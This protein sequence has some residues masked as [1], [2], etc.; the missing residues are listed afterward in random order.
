LQR[1]WHF[2]LRIYLGPQPAIDVEVLCHT[3]GLPSPEQDHGEALLMAV[4]EWLDPSKTVDWA[5][6]W[7]DV[8]EQLLS[9]LR[10]MDQ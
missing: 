6:S 5:S 9:D 8:A 10:F 1:I 2:V 7:E 4:A 3:L